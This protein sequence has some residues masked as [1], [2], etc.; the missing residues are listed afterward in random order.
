MIVCIN[1]YFRGL[2]KE[3]IRFNLFLI[4]FFSSINCNE[5]GVNFS[6]LN[7]QE[8]NII[9]IGTGSTSGT[10]FPIGGLIG[11]VI[12][13][14]PGSRPCDRG[15]SCGVP[16]LIA[17]AQSTG[18]SIDN[19]NSINNGQMEVGLSQADV[20]YWAF[21]ASG[22]FE[23][24]KAKSSIRALAN[25]FP[26]NVHLVSRADSG[27][28]KISDLNGKR[29]SFGGLK[30]GSRVDAKLILSAYGLRFSDINIFN[31]NLDKAVEG[32]QNNTLDALFLV[33]GAPALAILDLSNRVDLHFVP[34][35][36][37]IAQKLVKIFPFFMEGEIPENIY[38]NNESVKT[39][40]VGALIITNTSMSNN[41]A[42][43]IV[44]AVWHPNV[45]PLFISGHPRGEYM[46]INK[47]LN[48]IGFKIHPGALTYYKEM[49][50]LT[51]SNLKNDLFLSPMK[52]IP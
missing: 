5:F 33:S 48:G 45:K 40:N 20:A 1:F 17:V 41:L 7:S 9:R 29:V 35:D 39:L 8:L 42:Y 43:G 25:L 26:E 51:E 52:K 21:H 10:Y 46:D 13:N 36:G 23:G 14:P 6:T 12:S 32:I 3:L 4:I 11:N 47:A 28:R 34:I 49:G 19:I 37:P 18:G 50:L 44:K 16:G 31:Y 30:S 22:Y 2:C 24:K 15:G 27:I 38:G